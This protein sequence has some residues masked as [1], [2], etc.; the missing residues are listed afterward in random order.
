MVETAYSIRM[1][2]HVGY[3]IHAQ[4]DAA[5]EKTLAAGR[6]QNAGPA[7][8]AA[9]DL[10]YRLFHGFQIDAKGYDSERPANPTRAYELAKWSSDNGS[11]RGSAML[12]QLFNEGPSAP[13]DKF[14]SAVARPAAATVAIEPDAKERPPVGRI[15]PPAANAGLPAAT[16]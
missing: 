6:D 1:R 11:A 14:T 12:G 13:Q 9:A 3:L 16:A 10:A 4:P 5:L 7:L 15:Q 8:G 2:Q